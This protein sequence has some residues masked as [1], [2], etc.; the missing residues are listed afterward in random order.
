MGSIRVYYPSDISKQR[1]VNI[2][3]T[4]G[5]RGAK[6]PEKFPHHLWMPLMLPRKLSNNPHYPVL[7]E[8][9]S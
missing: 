8:A 2:F 6:I 7:V 9:W 1:A 3:L 4:R 5:E